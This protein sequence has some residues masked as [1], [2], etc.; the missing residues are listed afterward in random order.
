MIGCCRFIPS[1]SKSECSLV[2]LR[3]R[4]NCSGGVSSQDFCGVSPQDFC[5]GTP[6]PRLRSKTALESVSVTSPRSAEIITTDGLAI[7]GISIVAAVAAEGSL[8]RV[9]RFTIHNT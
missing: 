8:R 4:A 9:P 3:A 6:Q 7:R 1:E 2:Q 5:G